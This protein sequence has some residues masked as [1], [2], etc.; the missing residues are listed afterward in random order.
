MI[1]LL[2]CLPLMTF[3]LLCTF[4]LALKQWQHIISQNWIPISNHV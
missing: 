1:W 2:I 4:C 3:K